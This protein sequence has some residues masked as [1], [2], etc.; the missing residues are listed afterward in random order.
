MPILDIE[1][2]GEPKGKS[3]ENL[4]R[5]IADAAGK[6]MGTGRAETWVKIKVVPADDY[7]ENEETEKC[8][9]VFVSILRRDEKTTKEIEKEAGI[10]TNAIAKSCNRPACNAHLCYE[11]PAVGRQTF[12]GRLVK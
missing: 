4:A 12:G 1:I 9:P 11:A 10:L 3:R 2:V 5:K 6:V 7:A 8:S